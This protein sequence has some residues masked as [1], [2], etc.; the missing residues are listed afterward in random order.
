MG[1]LEDALFQMI[2]HHERKAKE[3]EAENINIRVPEEHG[4][5]LQGQGGHNL[6]QTE[7][8]IVTDSTIALEDGQEQAKPSG[9]KVEKVVM[10]D[11]EFDL[12]QIVTWETDEDD[13][14]WGRKYDVATSERVWTVWEGEYNTS[15]GGFWLESLFVTKNEKWFLYSHAY[16]ASA[17]HVHCGKAGL[18]ITPLDRIEA[19]EWLVDKDAD[20]EVIEKYFNDKIEGA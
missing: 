2:D 5:A 20:T 4:R 6:N 1:V 9:I 14:T 16:E 3:L 17:E 8:S 18:K 7:E 11:Y 15:Q 12:Q 10:V 13:E 19:F